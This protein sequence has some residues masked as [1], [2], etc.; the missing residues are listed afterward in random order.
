MR[1]RLWLVGIFVVEIFL[2]SSIVSAQVPSNEQTSA[3]SLRGSLI[4]LTW[5]ELEVKNA[6]ELI[7]GEAYLNR[8]ATEK[9][10]KAQAPHAGI[11]HLATHALINDQN[12]MYSK[13]IFAVDDDSTEDGF[14][15]TYELYNM[16]LQAQL[17]VLSA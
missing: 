16:E 9:M 1:T 10:F 6:A 8:Q 11:I 15:H 12:P 5:S 4:E 13:F 2:G 3:D 14:L 7:D 17:A